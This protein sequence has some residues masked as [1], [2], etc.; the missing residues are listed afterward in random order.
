MIR[1]ITFNIILITVFIFSAA[2]IIRPLAAELC[3]DRAQKLVSG[4]QWTKAETEFEK[5]IS[6][7]RFNSLYPAELAGLFLRRGDYEKGW[8]R[9]N[10]L[11]KSEGLYEDALA[12][13]PH[14]AEYAIGL[15]QAQLG[16]FLET[17][18]NK[19]KNISFDNFKRALASDPNGFN[20]SYQIGY[21]GIAVWKAMDNKEKVFILDRLKYSLKL[22]PSYSKY[23]YPKLWQ[24]TGD[25]KLLT[26]ITPENLKSNEELYGFIIANNLWQFRREEK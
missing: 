19:Y 10:D 8:I 12:L 24:Y 13:N 3:F 15:G 14:H 7:D 25:F 16:L 26:Q 20:V 6:I 21:A 9:I 1:R 23:I 17:G 2:A 11:K 4:Y 22:K 18:E 5:A